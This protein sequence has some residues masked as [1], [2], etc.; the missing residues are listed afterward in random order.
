MATKLQIDAAV[1]RGQ[2]TVN[3]P[4][5]AIAAR[6]DAKSQRVIVT[7]ASGI[8]LAIPPAI[9]Q[10]L[11]TASA[12][13]LED[14]EITPLGNGLYFPAIDAD[15]FIPAIMDGYTGTSKWMARELGRKGGSA[16]SEKKSAASKANGK[17]G[18]RPRKAKV[19]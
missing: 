13:E 2:E 17:L 14:I 8:E 6:Y 12:A 4:L 19:A 10:G 18:G 7:L 1:Q 3:S 15:V 16:T 9:V 11:S 5:R